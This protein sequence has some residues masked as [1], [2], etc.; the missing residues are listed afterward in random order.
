MDQD[1]QAFLEALEPVTTE[2]VLWRGGQIHLELTCYCTSL[3][4]PDH[5]VSSA[6]GI[7]MTQD[8]VLVLANPDGEHIMPGGRRETGETPAAAVIREVREETGLDIAVDTHA[9]VMHFHHTTPKPP[10]YEYPYPDFLQVVYIV[11]LDQPATIQVSD[12]YELEGTFV[13][14]N[15]LEESRIPASQ[16]TLLHHIR[17]T[18]RSTPV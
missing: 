9:V 7:I 5:L 18:M 1:L 2:D 17:N 4:P 16:W 14:I 13:P 12:T 3:E 8:Q 11:Q 10:L 6:R 15:D